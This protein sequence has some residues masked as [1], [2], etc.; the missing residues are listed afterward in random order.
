MLSTKVM[1]MYMRSYLPSISTF[2]Q[3]NSKPLFM[4]QQALYCA[5][6]LET[7]LLTRSLRS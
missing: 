5:L 3:D 1:F 4:S 6:F 2:E 7:R